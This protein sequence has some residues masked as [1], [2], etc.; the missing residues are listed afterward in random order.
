MLVYF[1]LYRKII[2]FRNSLWFAGQGQIVIELW[3]IQAY[4]FG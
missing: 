3:E 4:N 1:F 2:P